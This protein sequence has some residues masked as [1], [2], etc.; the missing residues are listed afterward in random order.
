MNVVRSADTPEDQATRQHNQ[1]DGEQPQAVL[2]L[3]DAL[4]A[5]READG[6][7]VRQEA[8]VEACGGNAD[9]AA[10]VAEANH[11]G[12]EVVGRRRQQQRSRRVQHV[13]PDQVAAVA[14]ARVEHHR[15]AHQPQRLEHHVRHPLRP[16]LRL[17]RQL[18]PVRLRLVCRGLVRV[19]RRRRGARVAYT[20]TL[21]E[22]D[23]RGRRHI[24]VDLL[25]GRCGRRARRRLVLDDADGLA[26]VV[27][28]LHEEEQEDEAGAAE[29]GREV[30]HPP[31]AHAVVD[32]AAD[33]RREEVGA[34][35]HERVHA[36][37][38][39][40][41]V[42]EEDVCYRNL[43]QR[44]DGRREEP[45]QDVLCNPLAVAFGMSAPDCESYGSGS[46][47]EIGQAL[48]VL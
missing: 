29:D 42:C 8:G 7:P 32:E 4:V 5:A 19:C 38:R 41:L 26:V 1:T 20:F 31:V 48:A 21:F 3:H 33:D 9:H 13:E 16:S 37:V 25:L 23:G 15:P 6:E 30:E 39:A 36:H 43:G 46:G 34:C 47:D 18:L 11:G 2:G 12:G 44:F 45:S 22:L 35:Q 10:D 17:H 24:V 27:G 28:L 40:S 14:E